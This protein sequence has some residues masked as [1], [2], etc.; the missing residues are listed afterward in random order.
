[1]LTEDVETLRSAWDEN[2]KKKIVNERKVGGVVILLIS[3]LY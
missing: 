1:M 3:L 2:T